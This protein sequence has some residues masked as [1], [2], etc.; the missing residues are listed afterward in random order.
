MTRGWQPAHAEKMQQAQP[1][2]ATQIVIPCR[3][4]GSARLACILA[5]DAIQQG[6][7]HRLHARA[8][9]AIGGLALAAAVLARRHDLADLLHQ[10]GERGA[11]RAQRPP[12]RHCVLR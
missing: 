2:V 7:Q 4:S 5:D 12:F 3:A 10:L 6:Q 11:A 1:R 9:A 8:Q